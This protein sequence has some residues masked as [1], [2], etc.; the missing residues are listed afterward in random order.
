MRTNLYFSIKKWVKAN[1][2]PAWFMLAM[3]VIYAPILIWTMHVAQ[4][5][6]SQGAHDTLPLLVGGDSLQYKN[7]AENLRLHGFFS[8]DGV[9]PDYFR[10]PGYPLFL[11]II[12]SI[13]GTYWLVSVFQII[14]V[15]LTC[16]LIWKIARSLGQER[17][18]ILGA[19]LYA[20]EPMVIETSLIILSDTIFVLLI[21]WGI[22]IL[23]FSRLRERSSA[24]ILAGVLLAIAT[25]FR[26]ISIFLPIALLPFIFFQNYPHYKNIIKKSSLI[27]VSFFAILLPWYVH[28]WQISGVFG[29]SSLPTYNFFYYNL[30][31]FYSIRDGKSPNTIRNELQI[32]AGGLDIQDTSFK[33]D[34]VMRK[35]IIKHLQADF[36][37]YLGFHLIKTVPFFFSS[38]IRAISL[39]LQGIYGTKDQQN[40]SRNLTSTLLHGQWRE[41][42]NLLK[43]YPL[44][45]LENFFWLFIT[46]LVLVALVYNWRNPSILLLGMLI[47]YFA[48][49]TGPVSYPRYRLPAEPELALLAS[50]GLMS[51]IKRNK[52]N[53]SYA[54]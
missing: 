31:E 15:Y 44:L 14:A 2:F 10:V 17:A 40:S 16:I 29:F 37:P 9:R 12:R 23:F 38:S 1:P 4:W 24:V 33:N 3:L 30:P 54:K 46:A 42:I 13:F 6:T 18:G 50:I 25:Y 45:T 51:V 22:Y 35:V 28:N 7:L 53:R 32:E 43:E 27:L 8:E 47:L 41:F 36:F 19:T 5:Q 48:I 39:D 11:A 26:P 20:F 21:V 34:Q 52:L 49:L